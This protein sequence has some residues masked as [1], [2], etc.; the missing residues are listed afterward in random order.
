ML[1]VLGAVVM[2]TATVPGTPAL[3]PVFGALVMAVGFTGVL[4]DYK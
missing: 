3:V 1:L 4:A 2:V